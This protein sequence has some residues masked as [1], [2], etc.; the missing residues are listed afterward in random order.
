MSNRNIAIVGMGNVGKAL[1]GRWIAAGHHVTFAVRDVAKARGEAESL[2]AGVDA[3]GAAAAAADVIVFA[4]PYPALESAA[5]ACGPCA[6]K[7]VVDTTN[8]LSEDLQSLVV[9]HSDS[10]GEQ[11]QRLMPQAHVVKCFNTT[12]AANMAAPHYRSG[13]L[14]MLFAGDDAEA[15]R[16]TAE[17]CREVGFDPVDLGPLSRARL[18]EPVA[19]TWI[20]LAFAGGLG[21]DFGLTIEHRGD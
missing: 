2:G 1:A 19:L 3:V 15:K 21:P 4:V 20:T 9:G 17:L 6:G 14:T 5:R 12:G 10:A 8:P 13:S 18:L 11:L 7:V 16:V